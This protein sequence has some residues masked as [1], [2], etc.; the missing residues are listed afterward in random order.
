MSTITQK[1]PNLLGGISQ[2]PDVKKL[3]GQ[4]VDSLNTFPEFALGLMKRPGAKF[5]AP[6]RGAAD[7]AKWFS[8]LSSDAKYIG[9]VTMDGQ[10][11][12]FRIWFKESGLPRVVDLTDYLTN[13]SSTF[14]DDLKTS[15]DT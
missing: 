5:E 2:Q 9:Q 7:D 4:V 14:Y 1:I 8:I 13:I 6:L 10:I 12:L 15:V 11:P 3:P